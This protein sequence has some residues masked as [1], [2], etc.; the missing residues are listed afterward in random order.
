MITISSLIEFG[1]TYSGKTYQ[2]VVTWLVELGIENRPTYNCRHSFIN[3]AIK[4][5]MSIPQEVRVV[6]NSDILR[7]YA[8]NKLNFE[9]PIK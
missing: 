6:G 1:G 8:G 7:N 3:E 2:G 4:V 9:I 5:G